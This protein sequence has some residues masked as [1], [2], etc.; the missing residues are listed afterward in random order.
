M[1]RGLIALSL[2]ELLHNYHDEHSRCGSHFVDLNHWQDLGHL[3]FHSASVKQSAWSQK[4]SIDASKSRHGHEDG[5]Q[6]GEMSK[7][8]LGKGDSHS[9]RAQ[10]FRNAQSGVKSHVGQNVHHG[11]QD[12]RNGDGP[13]Q[14]FDGILQ[15]LNDKVQVVPAV[16]SEQSGIETQGDFGHIGFRVVPSEVF[17]AAAAKLDEAGDDDG[18]QSG[19]FGVSEDVLHESCP[20]DFPTIDESQ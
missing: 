3:S 8:P 5:D 17:D 10:H 13:G 2:I 15:F 6:K 9:L 19:Q 7:H 14:I 12:T 20:F 11:D 18:G 1:W 4:D 16:V